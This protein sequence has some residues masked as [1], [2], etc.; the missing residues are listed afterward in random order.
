M[1]STVPRKL[2]EP[3]RS[4]GNQPDVM[5][6][7]LGRVPFAAAVLVMAL[8]AMPS[9]AA[10]QGTGCSFTR[11]AATAEPEPNVRTALRCLVNAT[12]QEHGLSTLRS[13]ARLNLAADRHSADM[14]ARRYFAHVSPDGNSVADRVR[15]TGYL[16]G[17]SDWALGEDIGWGTGSASTPASIFRSFMNS[18]PHSKIILSRAF[19]EIGVGVSPGVPVGGEGSGATF[20]LDFGDH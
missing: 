3:C 17:T 10:A 8:C 16:S 5:R 4:V 7:G 20:V 19:H 14:V 6:M 12:R 9:F 18:P 1:G 13:S 11:S 15:A 2:H